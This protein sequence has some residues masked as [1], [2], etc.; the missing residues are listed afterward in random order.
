MTR[1]LLV[2]TAAA[3]L[4]APAVAAP[5]LGQPAPA[6]QAVD[7][8]GKTRSLS[9]FRGKTVVLEWTNNGCPYVQKHYNAGAMQRLQGQAA[10][11][12]VVWLAVISSAPGMQGHLT[13]TQAMQ[14][15]TKEK[16]APAE[17]LLDPAGTMGRAYDAKTTPHMY[18][19]DKTGKLIYMGGIDDKPSSDPESLKGATNYV[20]AALADVKAGRPVAQAATRPYGCSVKYG[21]AD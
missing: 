12:G 13:G 11:D 5:V 14:W 2:F 7:A 16:A 18:V 21:S 3:A 1:F 10:K 19:V 15:K 20:A 9:E 6:F 8:S 4:A 17:V